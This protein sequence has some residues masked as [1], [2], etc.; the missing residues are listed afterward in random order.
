MMHFQSTITS[1]QNTW[2]KSSLRLHQSSERREQRKFLIEGEHL[3]QE[4]IATGWPL[5]AICFEPAWAEQNRTWLSQRMQRSHMQRTLLQPVSNDVL[6]RLSTTSTPCCVLAIAQQRV[7]AATVELEDNLG[8]AVEAMQDPG[9]LGALV[10]LSAAAGIAPVVLSHDSVDPTN[11]KV[12]RSTAGQWFRSVPRVTDLSQYLSER[13]NTGVQVL[14]AAAEG[15][16]YWDCDLTVPTVFLLGNEGSGLSAEI[17]N[18]TSGTVSVPMAV[19]VESLNVAMT[20]ALLVYEAKRQRESG[21]KATD[22]S[23][24]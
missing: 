3:V 16:R 12:L 13:R 21:R 1:C 19:G 22:R 9:N 8:I 10:R 6:K 14:A 7:A 5:E 24:K 4:A 15:K 18:F 11:P 23:A 2:V 20:G 17:R